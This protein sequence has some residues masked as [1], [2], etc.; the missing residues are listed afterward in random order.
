MLKE[1]IR[2][3]LN[4]I[5][6]T[7]W[8]GVPG[9]HLRF[10][11]HEE[12]V[13]MSGYEPGRR[14]LPAYDVYYVLAVEASSVTEKGLLAVIVIIG[15]VLEAPVLPPERLDEHLIDAECLELGVVHGPTCEGA[16]R[17]SDIVFGVV[18]HAHRE[19]L[20]QLPAEVLVH[21][22]TVTSRQVV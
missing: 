14:R 12:A 9:G 1:G 10:V 3:R 2:K 7:G 22:V 4:S 17:L 19:Q 5:G 20:Q 11:G 8:N 16:G 6:V 13:K 15:P 21:R 18:A